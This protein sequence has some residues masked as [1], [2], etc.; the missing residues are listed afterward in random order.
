[1]NIG[2][3]NHILANKYL[4]SSLDNFVTFE[5][6]LGDDSKVKYLGKGVVFMLTKKDQQK[7]NCDVY[8]V[9]RLKQNLISVGQLSQHDYEFI[10][11]VPTCTMLDKPHSKRL[12][13]Q[14]QMTKDRMFS[15]MLISLTLSY[16]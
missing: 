5:I 16:S 2:F 4:F 14:L 9:P 13:A 8:Y 1:L 3:N 15:L 11:N 7:D 6:K 12:I 10:F